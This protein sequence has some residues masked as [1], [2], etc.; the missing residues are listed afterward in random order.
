MSR[1]TRL[2]PRDPFRIGLVLV[3]VAALSGWALF[4]KQRIS[5]NLRD[6]TELQA[7][8]ARGYRLRPYVSKVKIAGVPVGIVT[9]SRPVEGRAVITMKI[10]DDAAR[11][12]GSRPR[13]HVRPT[14]LLGGTVYVDLE[15]G[16]KPGAPDGTITLDRTSVPVELDRVLDALGEDARLGMQALVTRS[17]DMLR[18]QGADA[19]AGLI[20]TGADAFVPMTDLLVAARGIGSDDL[21][22]AV[23]E[24]GR[25]SDAL[26]GD[27]TATRIG[28][29]VDSTRPVAATLGDRSAALAQTVD[30]L[31]AT[32]RRTNAGLVEL[33][34]LLFALET[35]APGARPVL[36]EAD[37]LLSDARPVVAEARPAVA[38][39]RAVLHDAGPLLDDLA[40]VTADLSGVVDDIDG[41]VADRIAGP[42]AQTVVRPYR[43]SDTLLYEELGYM[44]TGLAGFS[45]GVDAQGT[46]L[47]FAPGLAPESLAGLGLPGL[48]PGGYDPPGGLPATD[49]PV[50]PTT[51]SPADLTPPSSEPRTA[52]LGTDGSAPSAGGG[53]P[54]SPP[55]GR[56][57]RPDA[58]D[59]E[60]GARV[61]AG[62]A[63]GTT[64]P[65]RRIVP[66]VASPGAGRRVPWS[67]VAI[68]GAGCAVAIAGQRRRRRSSRSGSVTR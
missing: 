14:T 37:R 20:D 23:E 68:A 7:E 43:G 47:N 38:D 61:A 59:T 3:V 66:A 60:D 8:L 30:R 65:G 26:V 62:A 4:D 24:L 27:D 15:P 41:P 40:P 49:V 42:V 19:L 9:G 5:T 44:L 18:N 1:L 13:A 28:R 16:G 21:A 29:L 67:S 31:P 50:A 12:L 11:K 63:P 39:L 54:T 10:D 58:R 45:E 22:R 64:D 32:L 2:L 52:I 48:A 6:G 51:P 53:T 17:D 55:D 33:D 56:P 35:T 36:A 34:R 46:F 57:S 25:V